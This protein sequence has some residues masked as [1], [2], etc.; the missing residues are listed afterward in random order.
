MHGVRRFGVLCV[1]G[2]IGRYSGPGQ[3]K[4][5]GATGSFSLLLNLNQIPTPTGF[6]VAVVGQTRYF[7][8]WHRDS[9]GG[10]AV[11]NFTNGLNV[12]FQ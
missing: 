1:G 2:Q 4:N 5:S 6:V 7:Q 8:T 9:V 10:A 12:T 3:I 11:S